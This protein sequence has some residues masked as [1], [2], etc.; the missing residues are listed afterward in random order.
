MKARSVKSSF[1]GIVV[2]WVVSLLSGCDDTE[3]DL[4]IGRFDQSQSINASQMT[5][6]V[7]LFRELVHQRLCIL[8]PTY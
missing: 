1:G 2:S 4:F 5:R 7:V 8:A 6:V 3:S